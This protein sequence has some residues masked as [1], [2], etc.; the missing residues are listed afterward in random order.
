MSNHDLNSDPQHCKCSDTCSSEDTCHC[1][2]LSVKSWYDAEGRL[3]DGFDYKD[4]PHII[5]CNSMCRCNVSMCHNRV[6][7]HGIS[8]RLQVFRTW[9]MG[10]G[11]RALADIPKGSFVCEYVGELISDSEA[12]TREDSYL[13]DLDNRV[14]SRLSR[15]IRV[16]RFNEAARCRM[17]RPFA[18]TPTGTQTSPDSSITP[19][20]RM[21]SL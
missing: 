8:V 17:E 2:D 7:Q 20:G 12:D 21:S 15:S 4:P 3:K 16:P 13:F 1:A 6:V 18:S 11:V 14:R 5:E 9:G 10:W 19:V